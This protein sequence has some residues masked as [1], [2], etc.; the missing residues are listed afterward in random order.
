MDELYYKAYDLAGV[1]PGTHSCVS[2]V[3]MPVAEGVVVSGV[4]RNVEYQQKETAIME[5]AKLY[6]D[7]G[8]FVYDVLRKTYKVYT[9]SQIDDTTKMI[10]M[11]PVPN[12]NKRSYV[13]PMGPRFRAG[14]TPAGLHFSPFKKYDFV[15]AFSDFQGV[16]DCTTVGGIFGL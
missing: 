3:W 5:C 12:M 1:N 14:W 8:G 16:D 13:A 15:A 11:E 2:P 4:A 10:L 7:C 6:P 9:G